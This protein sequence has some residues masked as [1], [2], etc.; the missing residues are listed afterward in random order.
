MFMICQLYVRVISILHVKFVN[1][2]YHVIMI[3]RYISSY[4][5]Q[6]II[7]RRII[8]KTKIKYVLSK[9]NNNN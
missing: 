1:D 9:N 6:I 7:A 8:L 3:Y 5:I 4:R 2:H